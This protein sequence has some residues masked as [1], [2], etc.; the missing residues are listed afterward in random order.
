VGLKVRDKNGKCDFKCHRRNSKGQRMD[1]FF[2]TPAKISMCLYLVVEGK[3]EVYKV[4]E[5]EE[6]T[7]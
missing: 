1:I 5:I 7:K 6:P 3:T 2:K 4:W